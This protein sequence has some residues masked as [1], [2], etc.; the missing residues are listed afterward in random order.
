[1]PTI[2]YSGKLLE[3]QPPRWELLWYHVYRIRR[4]DGFT[5]VWYIT[6]ELQDDIGQEKVVQMLA[7][8]LKIE[9]L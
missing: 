5:V 1:M 3:C 4:E 2:T 9:S 8:N 6:P 7:D